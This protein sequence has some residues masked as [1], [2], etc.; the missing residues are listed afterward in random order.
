[1]VNLKKNN[2]NKIINEITF[3]LDNLDRDDR[4]DFLNDL[5]SSVLE[6]QKLE[7]II[8][9]WVLTAEINANPTRKD[10]IFTRL[11]SIEAMING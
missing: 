3:I 5:I 6:N 10:K 11:S 8:D 9:Q 7:E 1:M 4:N 2:K